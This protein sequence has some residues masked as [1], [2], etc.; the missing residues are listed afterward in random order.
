VLGLR[1]SC[2]LISELRPGLSFFRFSRDL[3]STRS[4]GRSAARPL[5]YLV[6]NGFQRR[7]FARSL[8]VFFHPPIPSRTL[9]CSFFPRSESFSSLD[10]LPSSRFGLRQ[11]RALIAN[12]SFLF[13]YAVGSSCVILRISSSTKPG[14]LLSF[15]FPSDG[16]PEYLFPPTD[17]ARLGL[18]RLHV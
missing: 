12:R 13:I 10:E 11:L 9:F 16:V 14:S 15:C 4:P 3:F 1:S 17:C 6:S 8:Y 2:V 5:F 18:R 7:C